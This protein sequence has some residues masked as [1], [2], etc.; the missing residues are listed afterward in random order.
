MIRHV[1]PR[2]APFKTSPGLSFKLNRKG[3]CLSKIQLIR[4]DF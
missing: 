2:N 3:Y 4:A 1:D